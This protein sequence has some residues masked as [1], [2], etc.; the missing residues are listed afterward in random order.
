M[1][2][3][4]VIFQRNKDIGKVLNIMKIVMLGVSQSLSAV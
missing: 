2:K 1:E 3:K 4:V